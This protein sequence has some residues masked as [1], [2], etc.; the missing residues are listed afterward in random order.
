[1]KSKKTKLFSVLLSALFVSVSASHLS[2]ET[3]PQIE[4][5]EMVAQADTVT[6]PNNY[7]LRRPASFR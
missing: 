1:M 2:A 6:L 4:A 7:T 3:I 5:T